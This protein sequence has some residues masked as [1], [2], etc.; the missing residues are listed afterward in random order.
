MPGKRARPV[1]RETTR[2]KDQP[3]WHPA[4]WSTLPGPARTRLDCTTHKSEPIRRYSGTALALAALAV[5]AVTAA[6]SR[7]TTGSTPPPPDQPR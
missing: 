4:A 3:R 2:K 1:R 7:T 5:R 6:R